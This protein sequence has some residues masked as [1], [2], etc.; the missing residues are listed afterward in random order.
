MDIY[1]DT[2]SASEMIDEVLDTLSE[3]GTRRPLAGREL[4][5]CT[6]ALL[7]AKH[8]LGP[9]CVKEPVDSFHT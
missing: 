6:L 9:A 4:N 5:N 1:V 3:T 8:T 2:R 7:R